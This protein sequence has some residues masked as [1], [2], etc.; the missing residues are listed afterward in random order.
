MANS[1]PAGTVHERL[2]V[3][4]V[5]VDLLFLPYLWFFVMPMSLPIAALIL[6]ISREK[7]LPLRDLWPY[8]VLLPCIWASVW[9]GEFAART[10]LS[11]DTLYN[12]KAAGQLSTTFIYYFLFTKGTR[13][14]YLLLDKIG[15]VFLLFQIALMVY[16][17]MAPFSL[18]YLEQFVYGHPIMIRPAEIGGALRYS[19]MFEDT[20]TAG[21]LIAIVSA[22]VMEQTWPRQSLVR[23]MIVLV[24]MT[25]AV[26][27]TA[28][29]GVLLACLVTL[30][31]YLW[32]GISKA[33]IVR[34]LV[35][36]VLVLGATLLV[37]R[38]P[39]PQ[40]FMVNGRPVFSVERFSQT[41]I[42]SGFEYRLDKYS[43]LISDY[44]PSLV[45]RGYSSILRPHSDHLRMLY[46]Y[47]LPAFLLLAYMLFRNTGK[48]GYSF[49]IPALVAFSVNSLIDEQKLLGVF[50]IL[51]A[52]QR[53]RD[54]VCST[55]RY[56]RSSLVPRALVHQSLDVDD[57]ILEMRLNRTTQ[58]FGI[59][60]VEATP[61]NDRTNGHKM[62]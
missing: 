60:T 16:H 9:V 28:S 33:T 29:R 43:R 18:A 62:G 12:I 46:A 17:I 13:R 53:S 40:T 47:G 7:L 58:A 54:R 42:E 45:G 24:A 34:R 44:I 15:V 26:F 21:Y 25:L 52:V 50:L 8:V 10:S 57:A 31:V 48:Q 22:Y 19:Y 4:L 3:G 49:V 11:V 5:A 27:A 32:H 41:E 51:V 37:A 38:V 1:K 39:R 55:R 36:L 2:L 59:S 23:W 6:V 61:Q 35:F 56:K 14:E 30:A 20:N